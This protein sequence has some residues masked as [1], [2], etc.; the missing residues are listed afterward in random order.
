[1]ILERR[2]NQ[3]QK[4]KQNQKATR[5]DGRHKAFPRLGVVQCPWTKSCG[6]FA[7]SVVKHGVFKLQPGWASQLLP[8]GLK[9]AKK[10]TRSKSNPTDVGERLEEVQSKD[11]QGSEGRQGLEKKKNRDLLG[12]AKE[13]M[14]GVPAWLGKT[15]VKSNLYDP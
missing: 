10:S 15:R 1:M 12:E 5:C 6:N 4:A 11:I 13:R 7:V 14:L 2:A 3:K 9:G 8:H